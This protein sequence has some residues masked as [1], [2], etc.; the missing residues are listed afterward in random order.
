MKF[1]VA[2]D[3]GGEIYDVAIVGAGVAGSILARALAERHWRVLVL[4]G[5][6]S[7]SFTQDG[8]LDNLDRYYAADAKVPNAPYK[9]NANAPQPDVLAVRGND[10]AGNSAGYF[11]QTGPLPFRSDYVRQGGGTTLHWLGS[12]PRMLPQ[13]FTLWSDPARYAVWPIGY[14]DLAPYYAKAEREIGVAADIADQRE[15]ADWLGEPDWFAAGHQFP[16]RKIPQS[17]VDRMFTDG[18]A[19]AD[20]ELDGSSYP[21]RVT[22]TPQGRNSTPNPDYPGGYT[23]VGAV[24]NPDIGQRC[25]GNSSC[26]PICPV[27]AK[28]NAAKSLAAAVATGRVRVITHAVV[29]TIVKRADG[30][31]TGLSYKAYDDPGERSFRTFTA[32]ARHYVLAA[33]AI[34]NAKLLLASEVG[35]PATG[36]YL[37]DHPVMLTWGTARDPLGTFRGPGSTSGV[38]TL[39]GGAFRAAHSAFRIEID[40]WGWNWATGAPSSTIVDLVWNQHLSGAALRKRMFDDSQRQVRL[41]FLM[42]IPPLASNAVTIEPGL[43]DRLGNP[44]PV[45]HFDLPDYTRRGMQAARRVSTEIFRQLD[46]IDRTDYSAPQPGKFTFEGEDY[47]YQGAGH[48]IGGHVMGSDPQRSVVDR[49]QRVWG[50]RNLWTVGCGN[51]PSEG[52]SNPTLTLAALTFVAADAID[53]EL[54]L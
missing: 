37:M 35:G 27:Q 31:V 14:R 25:Q 45:V 19:K 41:G 33:H 3:A 13:D 28:Y 36:Q 47:V 29:S 1:E 32:R 30:R 5:G 46:I 39:R 23:P 26:V 50:H 52:T 44:R 40:N 43:V 7:Q 42:E 54:R 24:G 51:M 18:L 15:L 22:S 17:H 21:V 2:A 10:P 16:M 48:V 11:K 49:D 34:E 8:Y 53:A 6:T 38:E 4:E 12:C 9:A 20:T